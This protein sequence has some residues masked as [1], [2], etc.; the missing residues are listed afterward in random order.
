MDTEHIVPALIR[1]K[2]FI[3]E[4]LK[5]KYVEDSVIGNKFNFPVFSLA[6][7]K[8]SMEDDIK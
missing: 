3:K 1:A 4:Y 6:E 8:S 7:I 2:T 5:R